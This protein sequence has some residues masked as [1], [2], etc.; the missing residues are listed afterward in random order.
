[1]D[2]MVIKLPDDVKLIIEKLQNAGYEAY[3]VG[4][5]IR[6]SMIGRT[7]NDW[8]ITTSAVP[9]EIKGLFRYTVDTG[10][11]HG[12]VTVLIYPE[13]ACSKQERQRTRPNSYEVTTYRIDGEYEDNRH[14]KEVTF[15]ADLKEDLKRRDFTINAMAYN[16]ENGLVDPC[17][18]MKDLEKKSVRCVGRPE[19]RFAE[20][21]LRILR[22][23]RF[24][25]QLGFD[26]EETTADAAHTMSGTLHNISA[27]RIREELVKLITSDHPEYLRKAY[28]LGITA[29]VLPEFDR[30][31]E[32][33]QHNIHHCYNVGE[34]I[35]CSMMNIEPEPILRL[36]MMF[37]DMGKPDTIVT[38]SDGTTHNYGHAAVSSKIAHEIMKRLKFDNDSI[39]AV[40]RLTGFHDI[41]I[42][43]DRNEIRH[44]VN[45]IGKEYF[46][47]LLK[48]KRADIMAKSEH[49]RRQN[50][51]TL[52][53]V[54][55]I[56]K[57]ITEQGECVCLNELAVTG[58]DLID[59]G[60]K[61]GREVGAVL[62]E[63]LADVLDNPEH[64]TKQY[65]IELYHKRHADL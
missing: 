1:M 51:E 23:V 2:N 24:S 5:C 28:E 22:A 48:V 62:S 33:P 40:T 26:I 61:Q 64:N 25:A 16:D 4:G 47:L 38:D 57:E 27:E 60:M 65:L 34:H 11:K 39:A 42:K 58:S 18:G 46:P 15:T 44:A 31:M 32:T 8:D 37:H 19:E 17:G 63:L 3:A 13:A 49:G 30:C 35:I 43:P 56:Y 20:D 50:L 10:I 59:A 14:P 54:E 41:K 7:P 53:S 12:T 29:I 21:A 36:T 55:S 6:D 9:V 45:K 52:S